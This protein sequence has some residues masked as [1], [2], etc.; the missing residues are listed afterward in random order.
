MVWCGMVLMDVIVPPVTV[1]RTAGGRVTPA[2]STLYVLTAVGGEGKKGVVVVVHHTG[3]FF[4]FRGV[5]EGFLRDFD[6]F[7]SFRGLV[8][9]S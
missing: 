8:R 5:S 9:E 1:V 3:A 6:G 4:V 2:L 7:C